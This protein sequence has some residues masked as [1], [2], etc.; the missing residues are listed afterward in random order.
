MPTIAEATTS[1]NNLAEQI[2][3]GHETIG[4]HMCNALHIVFSVGDALTQARGQVAPGQW[5]RW[6]KANC[7]LSRRTAFLDMQL[8]QHRDELEGRMADIPALSLRAAAQLI[9]KPKAAPKQ[10][11]PPRPKPA[12]QEAWN[13]AGPSE[14][15]T[16]LA[17]MPLADLLQIVPPVLRARFYTSGK[18]APDSEP[19]LKASEVLRKALSLIKTPSESN[20]NEELSALRVLNGLLVNAGIDEVTI[21]Q[22]HAKERR[23]AAAKERRHAA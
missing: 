3:T 23:L 21:V 18:A 20:T 19:F 11:A 13:K 9:A 6:L 14:R 4:Q 17:R 12:L 2:R 22:Q 8:A 10:K 16:V 1:L 7:F 15:A 5:E